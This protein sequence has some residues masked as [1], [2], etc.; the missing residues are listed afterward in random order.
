MWRLSVKNSR[1]F[2]I[3]Y[4]LLFFALIGLHVSQSGLKTLIPFLNCAGLL[5]ASIHLA[6]LS[7]GKGE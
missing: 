7:K 4:Q 6:L 5:L 2:I 3:A 1:V